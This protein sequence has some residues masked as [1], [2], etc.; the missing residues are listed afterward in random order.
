MYK[1]YSP[2]SKDG[3]PSLIQAYAR[4]NLGIFPDALITFLLD[5]LFQSSV[6]TR[7]QLCLCPL[8]WL[9]TIAGTTMAGDQSAGGSDGML[10][11]NCDAV[12]SNPTITAS[13]IYQAGARA[14]PT[15]WLPSCGR[16]GH[17]MTPTGFH[18]AHRKST[19][20]SAHLTGKTTNQQRDPPLLLYAM[21]SA[22][23]S[24]QF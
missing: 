23:G 20:S 2:S 1:I 17:K 4:I 13:E 10:A 21:G 7:V 11:R 8:I 22:G 15:P 16:T 6:S 19:S 14:L 3:S 9:V 5:P 24:C 12:T 18:P